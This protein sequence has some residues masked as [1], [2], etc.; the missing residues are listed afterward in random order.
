MPL[1][2]NVRGH[3]TLRGASRIE[4]VVLALATASW[5]IA[6]VQ[7][8]VETVR[9]HQTSP[10]LVTLFVVSL[11]GLVGCIAWVR[12]WSRWRLV[13]AGATGCYLLIFL[14]KYVLGRVSGFLEIM[15]FY[16]AIWWPIYS[17]WGLA[18]HFL[19]S[20][21]SG[22]RLNRNVRTLLNRSAVQRPQR[23]PSSP[24][25]A[26]H[27]GSL[28]RI[29]LAALFLKRRLCVFVASCRCWVLRVLAPRHRLRH[30]GLQPGPVP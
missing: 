16:E 4:N 3:M 24:I 1:M 13:L 19:A 27:V 15:P 14:L 17:T 11:C 7:F 28:G 18:V 5:S 26:D 2:S 30:P 21:A 9:S 23:L 29:A 8:I 12:S 20:G 22:A 25:V 6:V 10:Y